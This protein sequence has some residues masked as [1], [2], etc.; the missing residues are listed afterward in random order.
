MMTL[1]SLKL[2]VLNIAGWMVTNWR[3]VLTV[4]AAFLLFVFVVFAYKQCTKP[5]P[6]KLDHAAIN[7][8]ENAIKEQNYGEMREVLV[9][10]DVK[11]AEI[12]ANVAKGRVETINA[13]D[14]ARRKYEAMSNEELQVEIERRLGK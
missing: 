9:E 5:E 7:K 1:L 14:D 12:D 4:L 8:A 6:A 2:F 13:A 11:N 3:V 10:A